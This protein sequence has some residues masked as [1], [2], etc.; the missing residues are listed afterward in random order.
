LR[1]ST[2]GAGLCLPPTTTHLLAQ[3]NC[4]PAA[5][6]AAEHVRGGRQAGCARD[7]VPQRVFRGR[8]PR[9]FVGDYQIGSIDR[10]LTNIVPILSQQRPCLIRRTRCL[11]PAATA[12]ILAG[13]CQ[14]CTTLRRRTG[15]FSA[16]AS[17]SR[18]MSPLRPCISRPP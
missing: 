8:M 5:E 16:A 14:A 10:P 7:G 4:V 11:R 6:R 15:T 12:S 3:R 17:S 13:I 1:L 9:R 2:V 18:T